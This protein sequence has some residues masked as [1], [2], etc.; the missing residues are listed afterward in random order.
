[1][2]K[3]LDEVL[4]DADC[5]GVRVTIPLQASEPGKKRDIT[6]APALDVAEDET[7]VPGE[8]KD[9]PPGTPGGDDD[10]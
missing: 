1:M 6:V 5:L 2:S 7:P 8:A 4:G 9:L 10:H 3:F